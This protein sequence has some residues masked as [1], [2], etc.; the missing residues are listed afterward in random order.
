VLKAHCP[1][2]AERHAAALIGWGSEVLGNDDDFSRRYGWGPRL[3]L[4]LTGEDHRVWGHRVERV[5]SEHIPLTFLG[6]PTRY[7]QDGPPQPTEDP[8][9]R[10]GISITTCERFLERY[11]GISGTDLPSRPLGAR[12]W[13][14]IYEAGLLRLTAGEVYHD[15]VGRL[16]ELRKYFSYFPDDVWRYRVAYEWT[17]LRWQVDLISLCAH[18]G[19]TLSAR[20]ATADSVARI[21]NI[22]FLLNRVYRPGYLKWF[23]REF[24]K[25]PQLASEVGPALEEAMGAPDCRQIAEG[26]YSAI[27]RVIAFQSPY[28]GLPLPE[29]RKQADYDRSGLLA[30]HLEPV[31][32]GI[33]DSI[34]GELR[35]LP[36]KIGA[37]DQWV[38]DQDLLMGSAQLRSLG[39]IYDCEDPTIAMFERNK[40]ED[41]GV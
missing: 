34:Q 26:L 4:F 3:A 31:V 19:D 22:V 18:R 11:L 37:L 21:M 32:D 39:G 33:R 7:T 9:A 35:D 14:L 8:K 13:L 20:M 29:Y 17:V 30:Y 25:L 41:I 28:L 5:L 2:V 38:V 10:V 23:H 24:Y 1:E 6:Q 15:S 12:D 27:E 16:N 40:L 36:F